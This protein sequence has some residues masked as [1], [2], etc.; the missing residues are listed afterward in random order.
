M[1]KSLL[2]GSH[3]SLSMTSFSLSYA[4]D[5]LT[6]SDSCCNTCV[7]LSAHLEFI[8]LAHLCTHFQI[9]ILLNVVELLT[10]SLHSH[11]YLC[12]LVCHRKP[13]CHTS[14]SAFLPSALPDL[15]LL[16]AKEH[17]C[18]KQICVVILEICPPLGL[19]NQNEEKRN[20]QE[21]HWSIHSL[22]IYCKILTCCACL[23]KPVGTGF[24]FSNKFAFTT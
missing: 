19:W 24:L 17:T 8:N 4:H 22:K 9:V 15:P 10:P 21:P 16:P 3:S 5:A 1:L 11:T 20:K 13:T 2:W 14:L 12:L 6:S 23:F 18:W 7:T